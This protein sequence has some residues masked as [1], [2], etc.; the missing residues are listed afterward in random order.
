VLYILS[1]DGAQQVTVQSAASRSHTGTAFTITRAFNTL[2][3]WADGRSGDL[4]LDERREVGVCYN[5]GAFTSDPGVDTLEIDGSHTSSEYFMQLTVAE[6]QRHNGTA[7]SGAAIDG[8]SADRHGM[9][10]R[11]N[12][13]RVDWLELTGHGGGDGVASVMVRDAQDVILENLLVHDFS[14]AYSVSGIRLSDN[15]DGAL[16]RNCMIF[17]GDRGIYGSQPGTVTIENCTIYGMESVGVYESDSTFTVVNTISMDSQS[18]DFRVSR[19]SQECNLSS[20]STADGTGSI[21]GMTASQQF[22]SVTAGSENLHLVG[23][24]AA[25]DSGKDLSPRFDTDI[26]GDIR[27][28][29]AWDIGADEY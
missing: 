15:H 23:N 8:E 7:G 22:V 27:P 12:Y 18:D 2:Q 26:D 29:N 3:D 5:D 28:A 16:V 11:D 20:D 24:S 6:G 1:L 9:Y 14:D 17:N 10:V 4:A 13:T 21:T 19:V 25:V